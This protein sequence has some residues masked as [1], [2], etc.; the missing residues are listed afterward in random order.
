M[1][2]AALIECPDLILG[3]SDEYMAG[4]INKMSES[5]RNIMVI[6]GYGQTRSIPHYLYFSQ[7]ANSSDCIRSVASHKA[8]YE[9]I[10]RKDNAEMSLDKLLI[11]DLILH[12]NASGT[13]PTSISQSSIHLI[14]TKIAKQ[15][16]NIPDAQRYDP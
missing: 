11:V 8:I 16:L 13:L 10:V 3:L 12:C 1:M 6:T 14:N 4:L 2:E 5:H 15:A 7:L 9:N